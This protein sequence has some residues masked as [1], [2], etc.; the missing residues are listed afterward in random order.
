M[1]GIRI[2]AAIIAVLLALAAT[3]IALAEQS[4]PSETDPS[5]SKA[6][7]AEPGPEVVADRTATSRTFKLPEGGLETRVYPDPVNYREEGE[8]EW[9][10][11][12]DALREGPDGASLT[13]G[14]NDFA[15]RLPE[16]IDA[17]PARISFSEEWIASQLLGTVT[18]AVEL[19]G[20]V[21]SYE[22]PQGEMSFDYSGLAN[23]LK[24]EIELKDSSSP[25]TFTFALDASAGLTP[26]LIENGE[27][28]FRNVEGDLVA[29]LPAPVMSDSSQIPALS[30]AVHY[31]LEDAGEGTW[32]LKVEADREW[33][34]AQNRVYPVRIDP[35]IVRLE[36]GKPITTFDCAFGGKKGSKVLASCGESGFKELV[37]AYRPKTKESEDEW[38]RILL[39]FDLS[40]IPKEAFISEAKL[41]MNASEAALNTSGVELGLVKKKT[42][43]NQ[44]T[45]TEYV[46]GQLWKQEGGDYSEIVGKVTTAERGSAAG[47]WNFPL[48]IKPIVEFAYNK[49]SGSEGEGSGEPQRVDLLAKLID[50]K[51]RE[52]PGGLCTQRQVKFESS[53]VATAKNRPYLSIS[54]YP[55][56]PASSKLVSPSEGTQSARRFKLKAA[57]EVAGV[58]G[59][60]FQYRIG[61]KGKFFEI[62]AEYVHDGEGKPVS[63]IPVVG[64]KE[65]KPVYLDATA[66]EPKF[67]FEAGKLQL[68][69]LYQ[70]PLGIEGYSA[71][72]SVT[73]NPDTGAT[74]DAT[75][76]IGPGSVDLLTGDFTVT[77][78]D[79]TLPGL[80]GIEVSRTFSSRDAGAE[81]DTAVLGRGWKPT[82]MVESAGG[83]EWRSVREVAPTAE[84]A[85]EGFGGYAIL[86]DL[87]GYEYAFEKEGTSFITPPELSGW[88][89]SGGASFA[90][91]DPGGNKT[92]FSNGGSGSEY[93]PS[94]ISMTGSGDN[95]ANYVYEL[96]SGK[97]RLKRVVAPGGWASCGESS[98]GKLGCRALE[99]VYKPA[100]NWGAPS[101]DGE[102]LAAIVYWG[103]KEPGKQG[104]WEVV[105]YD[106]D[107]AGRLIAEWDPRISPALKET[108]TYAGEPSGYAGGDLRTLTPPGQEPWTFEYKALPGEKAEAGR[109]SVVKRASL[110]A[111]PTTA[112]TTIAYEVPVSGSGAPYEM[113]GN[114]VARWGQKD[115]PVQATAIFPPDEVPAS[116]PSSYTRAT[117]YYTDAEGF[118]VNAVTPSGAGTEAPSISTTETNEYGNVVR[119]LSPQNR[120]RALAHGSESVAESEQLDTKRLYGEKGTQLE[121]EW[122]PRHSV[123]LESGATEPAR[124]H[125]TVQYED[126]KEGWSGTGPNPHLPTRET[127]GAS[128][129][130]KGIDADQRV[131]ETKYNWT[132]LKPTETI[133]DPQGL[134]LRSVT[135]YDGE[136]GLPL[137]RRRPGGPS[138][139]DAHTTK[140]TYYKAGV[141]GGGCPGRSGNMDG[142][143]GLP[144]EVGPASQPGTGLP[145][146]DVTKFKSY[147][148]LL[149]PTETIESPGGKEATTRKTITTYD[150]AGRMLSTKQVGGGKELS[151]TATVYSTATGL[152]VEQ[153]FTCETGCEGFKS[154]AS[155]SEYDALGRLIKYTDADG[156]T[157]VTTY[158]LDGQVATTS[159]SK[160]SQKYGYDSVSGLLTSLEDS[161]AGTFTAAYNADGN[162]TEEALPDGI[163]ARTTYDETDE[164]TSLTYTKAS[165]TKCTF[166][167]KEGSSIYGQVLTDESTQGT[168]QYSYDKAGRL[169]WAKETPLGGSCTTRQY[170]YDSD[171]NRTKLT[172]RGP[173][174]VCDTSS[175]GT[176]QSYKYDTGDRLEGEEITYDGFGRITKLP[177]KYAGGGTLETSFFSNNMVASQSQ[178]GVTNTYELDAMGR[179]RQ[180]IQAGGVKG[181]EIFHYDGP[182]DGVA[183]TEREGSWTRNIA[184]IASNLVGV[185]SSSSTTLQL[186]DLHGDI[187]ATA[188]IGTGITGFNSTF[189]YDEFGN[190]KQSETPRYG[191]LGAKSRRTEL[192]SGV[193]QMGV[194][195][196]VPALGRFISPDPVEGGSA[197]AYDYADQDPING[198]DLNGECHPAFNPHCP[199]PPSPHELTEKANRNGVLVFRL[200]NNALKRLRNRPSL[201]QRMR[202]QVHEWKVNDRQR[203]EK[204]GWDK[205]Q[206]YGCCMGPYKGASCA[207]LARGMTYSGVAG[208]AVTRIPGVGLFGAIVATGST[209][210]AAATQLGN[211]LG[212]C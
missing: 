110:L 17:D 51:T 111:S 169:T 206:A 166:E 105:K 49:Q 170:L 200:R 3:S 72:N 63:E 56:A 52:C 79:F 143:N 193:I 60:A 140:T 130:G 189:Q 192:P 69:A 172:T 1:K 154:R 50:D 141:S 53:A 145:E 174:G 96:I 59:V 93:L 43:A 160:G 58:T 112:Q 121:E 195:T 27:V 109:L 114:E 152:P 190:P 146:L 65:T 164:P 127:T 90:L 80:G 36:S 196:Y 21:A 113:S 98:Q 156:N 148:Y 135:V 122:G 35:T 207:E 77:R 185:Q 159:D 144:C 171:S 198:F 137:E 74:S 202:G 181:T 39:H 186:T 101:A 183:W 2:I 76:S 32:Q 124:L 24:E 161:S 139:G 57:W 31:S 119:E 199:G 9:K 95:S 155:V 47:W 129:V 97:R 191:W 42:K 106:Y 64:A 10:P 163:L 176:S 177:G 13:N 78:S 184:S 123:S 73:V 19:E 204:Y 194:R 14:Q 23:G 180:R 138:G 175:E 84:E 165:C 134:N 12:G 116:P 150:T 133:T 82:S 92:V 182:S 187:V 102:R 118:L 54:Y 132:L 178:G 6:P 179:Q 126:L 142:Y 81:G 115:L 168:R 20:N 11:I 89:L 128:I 157:S 153:K 83:A 40:S 4:E 45:W 66:L 46:A 37:A 147:N 205:N 75:A 62:P 16:Q 162:L 212:L 38:S 33:L 107:S 100:T 87:E 208:L 85:E 8:E 91:V 25:N 188:G 94:E 28:A 55:A 48:N 30:H 108:Y 68:R 167:Q 120:L 29:A 103:P 117:V 210:G 151:P 88:S 71:P 41:S 86:T 18:E 99:F 136:T 70:G 197:N 125:R 203:I 61:A 149:Q 211:D 7:S 5:L 104:S 67:K 201:I 22:T 34:D 15:V 158:N 26:E 209:I 173:S 44:L 131:S